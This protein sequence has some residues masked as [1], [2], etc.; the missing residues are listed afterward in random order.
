MRCHWNWHKHKSKCAKSLPA[1]IVNGERGKKIPLHTWN[2][3]QSCGSHKERKTNWSE[4]PTASA[5]ITSHR[6]AGS[7][8]VRWLILGPPFSKS[9]I[10]LSRAHTLLQLIAREGPF[11]WI[12][13]Q[14]IHLAGGALEFT[15]LLICRPAAGRYMHAHA[16]RIAGAEYYR[17][18]LM[19]HGSVCLMRV[20]N[21]PKQHR[22]IFKMSVLRNSSNWLHAKQLAMHPSIQL[23]YNI[24]RTT[25]AEHTQPESII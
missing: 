13:S 15:I 18:R 11:G 14:P 8:C 21:D 22:A 17:K 4:I 6:V 1:R 2:G 7:M 19:A 20:V 10:A 24:G 5:T 3:I 12:N 23:G 25:A 16:Y 9:K